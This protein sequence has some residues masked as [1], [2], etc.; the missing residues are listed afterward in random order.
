M[1]IFTLLSPEEPYSKIRWR[2]LQRFPLLVKPALSHHKHEYVTKEVEHGVKMISQEV[3]F[4]LNFNFSLFRSIQVSILQASNLLLLNS[5]FKSVES[6]PDSIERLIILIIT[7]LTIH[8][9]SRSRV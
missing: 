2:E 7:E 8:D 3:Q 5:T 9:K 1:R 6:I 4:C